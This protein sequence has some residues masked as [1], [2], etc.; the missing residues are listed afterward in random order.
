MKF[1]RC[2]ARREGKYIITPEV[3]AY[4][5]VLAGGYNGTF[6]NDDLDDSN[7]GIFSFCATSWNFSVKQAGSLHGTHASLRKKLQIGAISHYM[8]AFIQKDGVS[9]PHNGATLVL[10]VIFYSPATRSA[11]ST[12]A[13]FHTFSDHR[14]ITTS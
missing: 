8:Y 11:S 1:I 3:L 2:N 12:E 9:S 13:V 5:R 6:L 4:G 14:K 10:V 7:A